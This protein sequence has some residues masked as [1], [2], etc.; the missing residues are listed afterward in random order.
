MQQKFDIE[1]AVRRGIIGED[2]ALAIRNLEAEDLGLPLASEEPVGP[3]T[4]AD[5]STALG[6]FLLGA[7]LAAVASYHWLLALVA[8][9]IAWQ[10]GRVI[11]GKDRLNLSNHTAFFSWLLVAGAGG[12]ALY[13]WLSDDWTMH[14]VFGVPY[15]LSLLRAALMAVAACLWFQRFRLPIAVA[16]GAACVSFALISFFHTTL[17]A[18]QTLGSVVVVAC[19]VLITASALWWD[20]SDIR[21]ETP[22]SRIAF[23]LHAL[24]SVMTMVATILNYSNTLAF[25]APAKFLDGGDIAVAVAVIGSALVLFAIVVDRRAWLFAGTILLFSA[26]LGAVGGFTLPLVGVAMLSSSR[27]WNRLRR[28]LLALLPTWIAAQLPRTDLLLVGR[29]PTRRSHDFAPR[30]W[31]EIERFKGDT[32]FTDGDTEI[33]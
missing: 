16:T 27:L 3:A 2:Q 8:G 24:A 32:V 14:Q 31:V 20:I 5:L 25:D 29:R 11:S 4:L 12:H 6:I 30:R 9:A 21:R 23:W 26:M 17:A 15:P 7:T 18:Y 10:I 13:P 33:R 28:G 19:C 1:K 22:R